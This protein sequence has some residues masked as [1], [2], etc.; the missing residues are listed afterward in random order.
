M[1][2]VDQILARLQAEPAA[3]D[4]SQ[5]EAEVWRRV[6]ASRDHAVMSWIRALPVAATAFALALGFATAMLSAPRFH[7]M[8]DMA[9]F[10]TDSPLAPSTR[11]A[12]QT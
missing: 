8:H 2:R 9:V 10:S 11:L 3:R 5:L 12:R 1:N 6:D 7:P 4:L